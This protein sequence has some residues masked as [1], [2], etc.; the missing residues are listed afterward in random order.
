MGPRGPPYDQKVPSI[1]RRAANFTTI[2]VKE[3]IFGA[4]LPR[5]HDWISRRSSTEKTSWHAHTDKTSICYRLK[6]PCEP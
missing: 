4:P 6:F 5:R 2:I 3:I 1:S